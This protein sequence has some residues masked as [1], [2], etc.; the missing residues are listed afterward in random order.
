M[1]AHPKGHQHDR[2]DAQE[3]PSIGVKAGLEG[4][5]F[6]DRQHPLPLLTPQ[7]SRAARDG[8]GVQASHVALVLVQLSSPRADRHPTDAESAGDVGVAQLPSLEQ[9]A[10]FQAAFF[11]LTTGEVFWAPDHGRLL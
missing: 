1:V 10:G 2:T 6:E 4:S 8:V 7:A 5:L 9:P 11:T 3:R